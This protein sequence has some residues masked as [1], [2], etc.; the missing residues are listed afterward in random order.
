MEEFAK[1]GRIRLIEKKCSRGKG[2]QLAFE[3]STGEYVI[4]GLDMDEIYKPKLLS[5]LDFYHKK[6]EG[7]LLRNVWQGTFVA[8]RRVISALGGWRD[9]QCRENWVLHRRAAEVD[10]LRWTI[11]LLTEGVENPHP[12]RQTDLKYR[13][14]W[15]RDSLRVGAALD[16]PGDPVR[17][18]KYV[19]VERRLTELAARMSFPFYESYRD[20]DPG[21]SWDRP[22]YF[23]DSRDWWFDG[24]DAEKERE[25][26]RAVLGR[27]FP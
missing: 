4:S 8:P 12:E 16:Y 15:Y 26:Y 23:V 9:L 1:Q 17:P 22:E 25:T 2:R 7:R 11:F 24:T 3:E 20:G 5:L 13:Y 19:R 6:C 14:V 21:F 18:R 10:L 27:E